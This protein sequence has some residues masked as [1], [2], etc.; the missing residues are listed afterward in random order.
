MATLIW[1][2]DMAK[3]KVKNAGEIGVRL[4]AE[5]L[6]AK[7]NE[8]VP[9]LDGILEG[10]GT[11]DADGLEATVS[12]G[13]AASAYAIV[14]HEHVE[15]NHPGKGRAKWLELTCHEQGKNAAKV[16]HQAIRKALG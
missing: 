11:V 9:H 2:G 4:G 3:E 13:G 7:A 6:V 5:F 10:S 16:V 15:F 14:Q 1:K 8:T 12:Y